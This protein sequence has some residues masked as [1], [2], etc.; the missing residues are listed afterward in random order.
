SSSAF[1]SA[2]VAGSASASAVAGTGGGATL[3]ASA[4]S[5]SAR[6]PSGA[7][8]GAG[9]GVVG[10]NSA[11]GGAAA[12]ITASSW[13][14][15]VSQLE[16]GG[17]AQLANHCVFIAR[18]GP[19]VRLGLDARNQVVRTSARVEKLTQALSKHLGEPVRLE[20]ESIMPGLETPAQAAER[21]T[22]E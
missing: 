13:P 3:A 19:V 9:A 11:A 12:E 14:T 16:L 8:S 6:A 7:P 22:V 1:S 20:F 2:G 21:A 17:A 18:R 5:S 15:L 10:V 4:H